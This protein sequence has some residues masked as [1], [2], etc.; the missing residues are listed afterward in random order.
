M[1]A[2]KLNKIE[3]VRNL[4]SANP[5]IKT[6]EVMEKLK[7][8]KTYTYVLMSKARKL[9][10]ESKPEGK[11]LYRLTGSQA[12]FAEK[13]GIPIEDYAKLHGEVV[14]VQPDPVNHPKHYTAGGIETIDFIEAK[15]LGY[16]LGNVVKYITRSGLKGNQLEDLRKAQ[17]YLSREIATLK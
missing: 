12:I 3:V 11:L 2:N 13:V 6:S 7:T 4:L 8:S 17:W 10:K 15:K 14:G 1:K 5:K 9:N 16:N